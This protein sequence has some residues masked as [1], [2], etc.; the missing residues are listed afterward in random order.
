MGATTI[1][2]KGS[3]FKNHTGALDVFDA[4]DL[5]VPPQ[6]QNSFFVT[7]RFHEVMQMK[8]QLCSL[9]PDKSTSSGR[10]CS[11][12]C[13]KGMNTF[14]GALT[15][16]CINST[17]YCEI[18]AWCPL[19]NDPYISPENLLYGV[20]NFSIFIRTSVQF[21]QFGITLT[22][23]KDPKPGLSL[24]LLDDI[25]SEA[26]CSSGSCFESVRMRGGVILA[27]AKY[28]CDEDTD[29]SHCFPTWSF[30]RIDEGDGF[31][32]RSA[33]YINTNSTE[34]ILRKM[35]GVR[36][37]IVLFGKAGRFYIVNLLTVLGAGLGLLTIASLFADFL[38]QTI[39]PKREKFLHD[40]FL[41]V[42]LEPQ[43][44]MIR[45]TARNAVNE[46]EKEERASNTT[47]AE[48]KAR[49]I[50][51][52]STSSVPNPLLAAAPDEA[53]NDAAVDL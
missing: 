51:F 26:S 50:R 42:N 29:I 37:V 23:G 39:W 15:G 45:R 4:V 17:T 49:Y 44:P 7:T 36:V 47:Y 3:A 19:E 6:M 21:P 34:R 48:L 46:D 43:V 41:K 10:K 52:R 27:K 16:K 31:N 14:L 24:F 32:F 30:S 1:K 5:V 40:K 13:P 38:L 18:R 33:R 12:G 9:S 8:N 2:I 20:K 35:Y 28:D 22:S 25:L 11:K 53:K